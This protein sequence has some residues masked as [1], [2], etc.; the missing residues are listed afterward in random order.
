MK[1]K[2]L[3]EIR[4]KDLKA[5]EKLAF[6]KKVEASKAKMSIISGKEK[7]LLAFKNLRRDLAQILT[8]IREKEIIESLQPKEVKNEKGKENA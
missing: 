3:T 2:D 7:N 5:L 6:D 4:S 1:K 8:I